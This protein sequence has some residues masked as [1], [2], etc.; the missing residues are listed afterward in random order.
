MEH[1]RFGRIETTTQLALFGPLETKLGFAFYS[2]HVDMVERRIVQ[3][4]AV[5]I[6]SLVS[7]RP[8]LHCPVRA[9][10]KIRGTCLASFAGRVGRLDGPEYRRVS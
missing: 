9:C 7:E 2:S 3:T 6:F 10:E 4:K 5:Q 1:S 8:W